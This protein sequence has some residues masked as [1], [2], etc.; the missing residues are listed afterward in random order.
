VTVIVSMMSAHVVPPVPLVLRT[1][2]AD[3]CG[4]APAGMVM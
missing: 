1:V 2:I 4:L 3:R